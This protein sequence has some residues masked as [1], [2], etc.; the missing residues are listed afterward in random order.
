MESEHHHTKKDSSQ[1]L[2]IAVM[3]IIIVVLA[4]STVYFYHKS[5][6]T[7]VIQ[8]GRYGMMGGSGF[9]APSGARQGGRMMMRLMPTPTLTAQQ[10]TELA[11]GSSKDTTQKTFDVNGGNFYFTPNKLTVNKGDKVTIIFHDDGGTH[12]F[13]LDEFRVKTATIQGG[14]TTAVTFTADKAGSFQYYCSI[15]KHRQNGMWGTLTVQ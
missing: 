6:Q 4:G 5:K 7:A 13:M 10:N 2:L 11:A 1:S 9:P 12:N 8:P 14:N 3:A 15:G